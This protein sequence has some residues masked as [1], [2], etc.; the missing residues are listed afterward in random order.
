MNQYSPSAL[1][2]L[3]ACPCYQHTESVD[4][5][6]AERGTLL[7]S[8]VVDPSLAGTLSEDDRE[9]VS[10][11]IEAKNKAKEAAGPGAIEHHELRVTV[12]PNGVCSGTL[13][14]IIR[15]VTGK[16]AWLKDW[17]F[18]KE[19]VDP[20]PKNI[21]VK[22][23]TLG[24]FNMF[25]L[26]ETVEAQI[27]Q[28]FATEESATA[29]FT[30]ADIPTLEA[31]VINVLL[32]VEAPDKVPTPDISACRYCGAKANC[33]ALTQVAILA[34]GLPMPSTYQPGSMIS[35]RDRA[36]GQILATIMEDWAK[37]VKRQNLAAVI[38]DGVEIPGF[39]LKARKGAT[40]IADL[41]TAA[42]ILQS[43]FN[44]DTSL[45]LQAC[46][47]SLPK[48][49]DLVSAA[50]GISKDKARVALEEALQSTIAV[51]DHVK[52]LQKSKGIKYEDIVR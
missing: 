22:S 38:E 35:V 8:V 36:I 34:S 2:Y 9:A 7:H 24:A 13:D 25:P 50:G 20:A 41:A 19:P 31:T 26:L 51:E 28:P 1:R 46:S 30:R 12:F 33:S 10:K 11:C 14:Y 29:V 23:Y 18:G 16:K 37:Q 17:K 15:D 27:V 40:T 52:W 44:L 49:V 39:D 5:S 21:Q 43:Q 6:A 45:M 32:R 47:M 4:T 3:A 48:L 42:Q